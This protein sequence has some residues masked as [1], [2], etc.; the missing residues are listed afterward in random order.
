MQTYG[1]S[2]ANEAEYQNLY[3]PQYHKRRD[4]T[5]FSHLKSL[6]IAWSRA[7]LWYLHCRYIGDFI[8]LH[9]IH[10]HITSDTTAQCN[11]ISLHNHLRYC[12]AIR[13]SSSIFQSRDQ[14]NDNDMI[15][16]YD[17][18]KTVDM[19]SCTESTQVFFCRIIIG[20]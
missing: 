15:Q 18:E 1:I 10:Y 9:S 19:K 12:S 3:Y 16:V 11:D 13:T 17:K 14:Y 7:R 20:G 2:S 4:S 8:V 6:F 5:N